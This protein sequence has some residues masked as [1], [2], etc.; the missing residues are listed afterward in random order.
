MALGFPQEYL[1]GRLGVDPANLSK[2][3]R[4]ARVRAATA[5]AVGTL[6]EELRSCSPDRFGISPGAQLRPLGLAA[7]YGWPAPQVW[8][9]DIDDPAATPAPRPAAERWR[10]EDLVAEVGFLR[11]TLGLDLTQAAERL[12]LS[13]GAIEK[14]YSRTRE[15]A[16]REQAAA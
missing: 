3:R 13:R 14:A 6:F 4:Q 15:R 10:S 5:K 11:A 9:E 8:G 12:G 7:K 2:T 1:A 16:G